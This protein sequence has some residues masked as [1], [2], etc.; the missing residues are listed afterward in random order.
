[1]AVNVESVSIISWNPLN[2]DNIKLHS[3]PRLRH[4]RLFQ[5]EISS[6]S[7][8]SLTDHLGDSII[9]MIYCRVG[10]LSGTWRK[11]LTHAS[12]FTGLLELEI[13][14]CGYS[15]HGDDP[16]LASPANPDEGWRWGGIDTDDISDIRALRDLH[17]H[18]ESN[19]VSAGRRSTAHYKYEA[20][21]L[22]ASYLLSGQ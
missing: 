9:T 15:R 22:R 8:E 13:L 6:R 2:V 11:V 4:I 5:T 18:V 17:R 3:S 7:L 20:S 12:K 19:R 14:R 10:L 21:Q 1:M 16:H